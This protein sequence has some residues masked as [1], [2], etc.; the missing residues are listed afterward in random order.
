MIGLAVFVPI[1][2]VIVLW[3]PT[4]RITWFDLRIVNNTSRTVTVQPCWDVDCLD[5]H[6]LQASTL[7]PGGSVHSSGHFA[8]DAGHVI[9]TGIRKPGGDPRRFSSCIV[10]TSAPGQQTGLAL[11]SHARPCFTGTEP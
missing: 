9:V 1:F 4:S 6:G 3:R 5:I 10:T 11:V 7:R 8:T 2:L